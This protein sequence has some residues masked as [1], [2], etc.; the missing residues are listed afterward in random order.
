MWS[1]NSRWRVISRARTAESR[2]GGA[3]STEL[4]TDA[5]LKVVGQL[6]AAG[7]REVVLIGGEAYLHPGFLD[8]I[9][10]LAGTPGFDP[11]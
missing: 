2:A 4:S 8:I 6:A 10:A 1:G 5:A 3:R 7:A 11:P 9:F